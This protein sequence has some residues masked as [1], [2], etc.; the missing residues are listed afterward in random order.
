M[1]IKSYLLYI[2]VGFLLSCEDPNYKLTVIVFPE[3]GGY[4]NKFNG[5]YQVGD[6]VFLEATP[7]KNYRFLGWGGNIFGL[8]NTYNLTISKDVTVIAEFILLDSDGDGVTDDIDQCN[9]SLPGDNV[10][11][12]G[13]IDNDLDSDN[14][15][16]INL[17]DECSNTPD[18]TTVNEKGCPLIYLAEN[19]VTLIASEDARD[20]IGKIVLFQGMEVEIISDWNHMRSLIPSTYSSEKKIVTT[21]LEET[22]EL[23]SLP[24]QIDNN[25]DM[26]SWDMSNVKTMYFTFWNLINFN[27]DLSHWDISKVT[28]MEGVFFHSYN[29]K[30]NLAKWN[31]SNVKNMKRLFRGAYLANPDVSNWDVSNV[32]NMQE[33]FYET[34]IDRD[35]SMWDVRKVTNMEKMFYNANNFNQDLSIWEV[36]NVIECSSFFKNADAWDLPKPSFLK[37]DPGE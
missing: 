13:C 24:C 1:R 36:D 8:E 26:T 11:S 31:V 4:V 2:I 28:S 34:K 21:F 30:V 23:C 27:Q 9:N 20:S 37:C 32:E 6:E 15:G 16:V 7:N 29:P 12:S 25:F 19:G 3:D 35:I 33:M 10:N 22:Q 17:I 5:I 18:N 14:D